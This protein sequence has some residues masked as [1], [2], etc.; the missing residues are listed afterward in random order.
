MTGDLKS[1][2]AQCGCDFSVG[3]ATGE[4]QLSDDHGCTNAKLS[5]NDRWCDILP[6]NAA[7]AETY[8]HLILLQ[9]C[10]RSYV[11]GRRAEFSDFVVIV[12]VVVG[13]GGG[14]VCILWV[15]VFDIGIVVMFLLLLI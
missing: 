12:V 6:C 9:M 15:Y 13:G 8:L 11:I 4:S 7:T 3:R 10:G 2:S 5:P 14:G 1:R